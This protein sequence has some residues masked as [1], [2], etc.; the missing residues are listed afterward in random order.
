MPVGPVIVCNGPGTRRDR[1]EQRRQRARPG[2]PRQ[3]HDR[4][5]RAARRAQ[6]RRWPPRRG[7]PGHPRQP[8]QDQLL[9]RRARRA[10]SPFTSLAVSRGFP[11]APNAVTVFAG[12]GPRCIVDQLRT[13]TREL[14]NV[15]RRLPAHAAQPKLGARVRRRPGHRAPS[16]PGCSPRPGGT[17]SR[18]VG[19][20]PRT[21]ADARQPNS[22]AARCGIAEGMPEH[23][24]DARC[25]SSAPTA[26]CW[27]TRVAAPAVLGHDR[28]L[29]QR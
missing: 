7:R 5:R 4:A 14:A 16:T 11:P 26:S 9:L 13:A 19:G 15:D 10:R 29:G 28:R 8:R 12:E 22:C 1:H 27:C 3:P 17:A 20:A 24:R 6:R 2:Q 21:A 18:T 23:L 25:P